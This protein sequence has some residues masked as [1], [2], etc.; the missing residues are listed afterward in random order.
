M[1]QK[2]RRPWTRFSHTQVYELERRF[3][4]Q[5]YLTAHE[6]KQLATMLH[7]TATQ[8]M[9]WFQNR[10]YKNKKH[11]RKLARLSRK[12]CKDLKDCSPLASSCTSP[13]GL[14]A[15]EFPGAYSTAF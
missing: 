13:G 2:K 3:Q 9:V 4:V 10:R 1:K 8:V 15:T 14:Q 5:K 12:S 7:L 6:H 11:Q